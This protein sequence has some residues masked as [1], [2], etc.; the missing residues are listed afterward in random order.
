MKVLQVVSY[1]S[2]AFSFGGPPRV[3]FDLGKELVGRGH[4]V[5]VYTTDVLNI[6]NWKERIREKDSEINGVVVHRFRRAS[7]AYMLPTKFLKLLVLEEEYS[8]ELNNF[9]IIHFSEI[10]HPLAVHFCNIARKLKIPYIISIFGNLTPV[11]SSIMNMFRTF[12]DVLWG[13]K[14]LQQASALLVQTPHEEEMCKSYAPKGKIVHLSLPVDL[15][16]FKELPLRGL[17]RKKHNITEDEKII[18][19][20]GR[21]HENKGVQLLIKAFATLTKEFISSGPLV[22]AGADEGYKVFLSKLVSSF[23]IEDKVI[24][25]GPVFGREKLEAYVDADVFVLTPNVYEE[26]SLAALE[27]AACGTPVIVTDYNAIPGLQEYDAGFQVSYDEE[28][29]KEALIK[30]LSDDDLRKKMGINARR[31]IE[32]EYSLNM[33]TARLEKLFEQIIEAQGN[34]KH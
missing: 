10:T 6:E 16:L 20:L 22:I 12:F 2:P 26:T 3:M 29:L 9:D 21:I 1:Y 19:F 30:I 18:L 34:R 8:K 27:A 11:D 5:Q 24:F 23:C 32:Q 14:I 33:V 28:R 13:Q 4:L 25:T 7:F 31:L 15:N 17:F